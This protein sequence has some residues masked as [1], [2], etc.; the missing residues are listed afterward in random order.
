M[1]NEEKT[2]T[3]NY[4]DVLT[5]LSLN[6]DR[7]FLMILELHEI[8]SKSLPLSDKDAWNVLHMYGNIQTLIEI[9]EDYVIRSRELIA[10][11]QN[12]KATRI[13]G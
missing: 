7:T 5:E 9:A 2:G 4:D 12:V 10:E 1:E 3:T 11:T 13:I 8:F 6:L